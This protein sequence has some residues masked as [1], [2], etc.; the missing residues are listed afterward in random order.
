MV[1]FSARPGLAQ[2]GGTTPGS[3]G[4]FLPSAITSIP[5]FGVSGTGTV[6]NP[7]TGSG[8][9]ALASM[10]LSGTGAIPVPASYHVSST[11]TVTPTSTTNTITLPSGM[12]TGD[13]MICAVS[14]NSAVVSVATSHTSFTKLASA[15]ATND[16]TATAEAWYAYAAS[17]DPGAVCTVTVTSADYPCTAFASYSNPAVSSP[18]DSFATDHTT[19][20]TDVTT[21]P[22]TGSTTTTANV[23]P[24][25]VLGAGGA[26]ATPTLTPPSGYTIRSTGGGG[27]FEAISIADATAISSSGTGYGTGSWTYGGGG[28]GATISFAIKAATAGN[29]GTGSAAGAAYAVSGTGLGGYIGTGTVTAASPN[30]SAAGGVPG[31]ISSSGSVTASTYTPAAMALGGNTTSSGS[32]TGA[33]WA[34]SN[35]ATEIFSGSGS[36]SAATRVLS[37][38]GLGGDTTS[39]GTVAGA[40]FAVLGTNSQLFTSSGSVAGAA[41]G[42]AGIGTEADSSTGS[43]GAAAPAVSGTAS[44]YWNI[45]GGVAEASRGIAASGAQ[46]F[47]GTG[48]VHRA[49]LA[50]AGSAIPA[51]SWS[52]G[53]P[54]TLVFSDDFTETSL[55]T[56]T[57]TLGWLETTGVSGPINATPT[58]TSSY[59]STN[60]TLPGDGTLH[61]KVTNNSST[62][63][64]PYTGACVTTNPTTLGSGKGFQFT[65]GAAEARIYLPADPS[66]GEIANWP[67]WWTDGQSW[68]TDGEIDILE[69]LGGTAQFHMNSTLDQPGIGGPAPGQSTNIYSG[70]W[71]TYGINWTSAQIDYYF[72]GVLVGTITT[73]IT[74]APMYLIFDYTTGEF[75]GPLDFADMQV[76]WV[77]VWDAG[78]SVSIPSI[79]TLVD[80]FTSSST[81]Y[82]LWNFYSDNETAPS[83][84]GGQAVI[85]C[86]EDYESLGTGTVYNMTGGAL[87]AQVTPAAGSGCQSGMQLTDGAQN[88]TDAFYN[89]IIWDYTQ[90]VGLVAS[91]TQAGTVTTVGTLTYN[92]TTHAWWRIRESSGTIYWDTAPD[93]STW[94]NRYS[95]SHSMAVTG[96][97]LNFYSGSSTGA[98]TTDL[99]YIDNVNGGAF[100]GTGSVS[101][102]QFGTAGA[103]QEAD[104]IGPGSVGTATWALS[105]NLATVVTGSGSIRANVC[106]LQSQGGMAYTCSGSVTAPAMVPVATVSE[107]FNLTGGCAMPEFD[108]T[109]FD[110][111]ETFSAAGSPALAVLAP[112]GTGT[113]TFTS[114]GSLGLPALAVQ[115]TSTEIYA[116]TGT[117]HQAAMALHSTGLGGDTTS[118]GS[119]SLASSGALTATGSETYAGTALTSN[120]AYHPSG[121]GTEIFMGRGGVS[122]HAYGIHASQTRALADHQFNVDRMKVTGIY[123]PSASSQAGETDSAHAELTMHTSSTEALTDSL[124]AV[125]TVNLHERPMLA[126]HMTPYE[127]V[128]IAA[129]FEFNIRASVSTDD[130][131]IEW[132]CRKKVTASFVFEWDVVEILNVSVEFGWNISTTL[133]TWPVTIEWN[134]GQAVQSYVPMIPKNPWYS[135]YGK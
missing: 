123:L 61:L 46:I 31:P 27:D 81:L 86:D 9:I 57:W 17:G 100:T 12:S 98:V 113:E 48:S 105:G 23:L 79:N 59:N 126:D 117:A 72:D 2:P 118:S 15:Q 40:A 104:N 112:S 97:Y 37:A 103:G 109:P 25:S 132:D 53:T 90:G 42:I 124:F 93:G 58:E 36:T 78:S 75:A 20:G 62:T 43:V 69:G 4:S 55:S 89:Q 30:V 115:A 1:A 129:T 60:V 135:T 101:M 44:V 121:S 95:H 87:Y 74:S 47:S 10:S 110:G 71:H 88:N 99:T 34:I 35:N 3:S 70:G 11:G 32:A 18:I 84:T 128:I 67:A 108:L 50:L 6:V 82:T 120:P 16:T 77:R 91:I 51:P 19:S 24:I 131:I 134:T 8:S 56:T 21:I 119:V 29:T 64:Y 38:T 96:L 5:A 41:F 49:A 22:C 94:T 52:A 45:T 102:A 7:L 28:G 76:D 116:G 130:T 39:S 111:T 106:T 85:P 13:L 80:S 133:S 73:G 54:W 127:T 122:A 65:Y 66:T 68:P 107:I 14:A 33:T 83:I 114:S 125:R 26:T 63:G 92:A